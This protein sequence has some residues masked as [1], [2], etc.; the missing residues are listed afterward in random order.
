MAWREA[1][2]KAHS[3]ASGCGSVYER[4]FASRQT[5]YANKQDGFA[6]QSNQDALE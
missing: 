3:G 4:V 1:K 6:L 5:M 2:I